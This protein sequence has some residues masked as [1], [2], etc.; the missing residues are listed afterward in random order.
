MSAYIPSLD[1]G[2]YYSTATCGVCAYIN[3]NGSIK[4]SPKLQANMYIFMYSGQVNIMNA[5]N[6]RQLY[7]LCALQCPALGT[8]N[9]S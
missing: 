6:G 7:M 9:A 2:L 3:I 5:V 1:C 4:I 8:I